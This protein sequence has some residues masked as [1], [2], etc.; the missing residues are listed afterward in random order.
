MFIQTT[1]L[2]NLKLLD[3]DNYYLRAKNAQESPAVDAAGNICIP[4]GGFAI[5]V[6]TGVNST[7]THKLAYSGY[8]VIRSFVLA[9]MGSTYMKV[10]TMPT[11]HVVGNTETAATKA[12]GENKT[13]AVEQGKGNIIFSNI[14]TGYLD[15]LTV[16]RETVDD[17]YF[18]GKLVVSSTDTIQSLVERALAKTEYVRTVINDDAK[19]EGYWEEAKGGFNWGL[20]NQTAI[21]IQNYIDGKSEHANAVNQLKSLAMGKSYIGETYVALW[22]KAGLTVY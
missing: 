5:Q 11:D 13:L 2:S 14:F 7:A 18:K 3:T 19:F 22:A 1:L 21:D 12:Y 17:V 20:P 4:E 6:W 15:Y 10:D 9:S 8:D 16:T